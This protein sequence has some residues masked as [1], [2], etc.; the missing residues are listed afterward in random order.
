[1]LY[2]GDTLES[3]PVPDIFSEPK[4]PYTQ[5]L[6]KA[7]PHNA[8]VGEPL[9]TIQDSLKTLLAADTGTAMTAKETVA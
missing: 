7:N 3:A 4:H 2:H 8:V 5:A 9:P 1:V 6:L